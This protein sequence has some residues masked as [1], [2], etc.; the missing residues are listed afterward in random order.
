MLALRLFG[1]NLEIRVSILILVIFVFDVFPPAATVIWFLVA[2]GSILIHELGHAIV[3]DRVGGSVDR[4]VLYGMG[5][6]TYSRGLKSGWRRFAVSFAGSGVQIT[7]GLIVYAL[8]RA[9]VP[10]GAS[11]YVVG[12]P[13]TVDFFSLVESGNYGAFAAVT[14]MWISVFWGSFNLLPIAGLDG[15]SMLAEVIEK[16]VPGR[17]RFHAAIIGLLVSGVVGYLLFVRGFTLAPIILIYF[18]LNSLSDLRR[19]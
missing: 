4:I 2:A 14:F 13:W 5:G 1:Y 10:A 19:K 6:L 7:I 17:G 15:S 8:I 12:N 16:T 11:R 18:A 9:G 3:T